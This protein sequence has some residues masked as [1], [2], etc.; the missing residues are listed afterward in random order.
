MHPRTVGK[1]A[2]AIEAAGL[3]ALILLV[4]AHRSLP[5]TVI[6]GLAFAY[7]AAFLASVVVWGL[8]WRCPTCRANLPRLYLPDARTLI[9]C[10][11]CGMKLKIR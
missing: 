1:L 9:Y 7:F 5:E 8:F 10:P 11:G 3:T 6:I 2:K 4:L